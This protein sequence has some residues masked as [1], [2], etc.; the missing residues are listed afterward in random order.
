MRFRTKAIHAGQAPDPQHGAVMTPVYQTSTFAFRSAEDPGEFDYSRS[1]NPTRKALEECLAQLESGQRAF[2]FS[3]GMAAETTVMMQYRAGDHVVVSNECYGG[4]YRLMTTVMQPL[5]IEVSFEDFNDLDAVRA[6][7]R[8]NT[9]VVW[10]ESPTNPL[11]KVVDIAALAAIAHEGGA[12]A[13]VDNTFLSPYFQNPL[14]LGADIVVHSTTKYLNG[15]SDVVGGCAITNDEA[16][17]ARLAHLQNAVGAVPGPWEC[18]LVMRGIKTLPLR[19]EAHQANALALAEFLEAHPKIERVLHPGLPSHPQH[20]LAK[21]QARGNGGTFS[22]YVKGGKPEA[23]ALLDNL[24]LFSQA[25]SLGG[26]ESLIEYP[27]TMT[28]LAVPE[29]ERRKMGIAAN[30][31]RVSIGIEDPA[32]LLEDFDRALQAV[33]G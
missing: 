11:M 29:D 7:M 8:P 13:I 27:W 32:D 4:T 25:V 1:G 28:H 17:A 15:H 30:L 24:E 14:D 26:V 33:K 31:V 21:R 23:Y 3:T 16:I 9:K 18:F 19:M 6:A 10:I 2:A 5:G 22:F 12:H 20:E